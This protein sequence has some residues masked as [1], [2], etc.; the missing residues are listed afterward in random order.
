MD[1]W[2]KVLL[3]KPDTSSVDI[4]KGGPLG[5]FLPI[6]KIRVTSSPPFL[7]SLD[8]SSAHFAC[9]AGCIA[10]RNV[11]SNMKSYAAGFI[12]CSSKKFPQRKVA[13]PEK[14]LPANGWPSERF[15]SHFTALLTAVGDRSR[16]VALKPAAARATASYTNK[17]ISSTFLT[18]GLRYWSRNKNKMLLTQRERERESL[19]LP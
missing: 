15:S 11:Q 1:I 2:S 19:C 10:Q 16:P 7:M 12:L 3:N 6:G 14:S 9:D 8:I 5:S 18:D 4:G 13:D 17:H